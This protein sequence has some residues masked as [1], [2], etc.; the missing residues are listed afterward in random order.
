MPLNETLLNL[1]WLKC[2]SI[3]LDA[4]NEK[5]FS[6]LLLATLAAFTLH[7]CN[8]YLK[9]MKSSNWCVNVETRHWYIRIESIH[10]ERSFSC[11]TRFGKSTFRRMRS[12]EPAI[13]F[14]DSW[15][16]WIKCWRAA[17]MKAIVLT[18]LWDGWRGWGIKGRRKAIWYSSAC[19]FMQMWIRPSPKRISHF[20]R[21]SMFSWFSYLSESTMKMKRTLV[22]WKMRNL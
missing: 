19:K 12:H 14:I 4:W 22:G 10:F 9:S 11:R 20:I 6:K 3:I 21:I 17:R 5:I 13:D 8:F 15:F 7:F 1:H 16:P 18:A 2:H